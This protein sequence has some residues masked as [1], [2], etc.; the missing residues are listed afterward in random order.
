MEIVVVLHPT[1]HAVP[2]SAVGDT[3]F[4]RVVV[5]G[6]GFT[7]VHG[8]V[9]IRV[10]PGNLLEDVVIWTGCVHRHTCSTVVIRVVSDKCTIM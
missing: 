1:G 5:I 3:F 7:K 8:W 6:T 10:G 4:E 2:R 9:G